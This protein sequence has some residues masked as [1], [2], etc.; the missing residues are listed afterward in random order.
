MKLSMI[1]C[2]FPRSW[3]SIH[4]I[5][6]CHINMPCC[7]CLAVRFSSEVHQLNGPSYLA[8]GPFSTALG[9][10][11]DVAFPSAMDCAPICALRRIRNAGLRGLRLRGRRWF[12]LN[13]LS[14]TFTNPH[15]LVFSQKYRRYNWEAYCGTNRRRTAVQI[16]HVLRRFPVS[17]V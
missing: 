2:V 1:S 10:G 3:I 9:V 6:T 12:P 4:H 11:I 17:K 16:G 13:T 15:P 14:G 7:F 8:C 5:I